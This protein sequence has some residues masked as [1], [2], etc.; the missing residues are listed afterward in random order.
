M[1]RGA[2][3]AGGCHR[4][5]PEAWAAVAAA[6]ASSSSSSVF[7]VCVFVCVGMCMPQ[8][9]YEDQRTITVESL[10]A[11]IMWVLEIELRSPGLAAMTFSF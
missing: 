6:A 9:V 4:C 1:T 5:R 3:V 10:L 7:T 2:E 8:C 11:S